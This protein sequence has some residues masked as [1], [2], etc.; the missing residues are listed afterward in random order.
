MPAHTHTGTTDSAGAH[1]HTA[2]I[3][4]GSNGL[5][6]ASSQG[7]ISTGNTSSNGAHTHTFT[8]SSTGSGSA[9]TITNPYVMLHYIIKT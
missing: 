7:G 8:T 5:Y 6:W 3:A 4:S 1:M 2:Y 9:V